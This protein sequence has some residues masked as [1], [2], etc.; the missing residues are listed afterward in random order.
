MTVPLKG[1]W[2][3]AFVTGLCSLVFSAAAM[4]AP[5]VNVYIANFDD[6]TISII[7]SATNTVTATINVLGTFPE[8]VAVTP[9]GSKVLFTLRA[10]TSAGDNSNG[11][12]EILDTATNAVIAQIPTLPGPVGVV[13]APN[14]KTAYIAC[15]NFGGTANLEVLDLGSNTITSQIAVNSTTGDAPFTLAI[16]PD[17]TKLYIVTA[18][19]NAPGG[20]LQVVNVAA[21]AVTASITVGNDPGD[22]AI[23]PNGSQIYVSN[24]DDNSVSVISAAT[25]TVTA[26]IPVG[27]TPFGVAVT[28]DG[29]QAW[30]ANVGDN[31]ISIIATSTNKVISTF[32]A[33]NGAGA[34]A[35]GFTPDGTTAYVEDGSFNV[36]AGDNLVSVINTTSHAVTASI[37]VGA[38][39]ISLGNFI[40]TAPAAAPA[41]SLLSAV[42]PSSRAVAVGAPATIFATILNAS[43]AALGDCQIT[44]PASAPSGLALSYQT[45]NPA[46]NAPTGQPNTPVTIPANGSQSFLL[47]FTSASAF[48][49]PGLALVYSCSGVAQVTPVIGLNTVDLLFSATPIPDIIA[50][51]ATATPGVV[52]VPFSTGGSA[53]F[54]VATDNVGAAGTLTASVDTG[55]ASLPLSLSLCQT[56]SATGACLASPAATASVNFAAGASPTFSVF[57]T[58]S[59]AIPFN[60]ANSRLFVRFKNGGSVSHGSTSVAVMTK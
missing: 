19:A 26:T 22:V 18:N 51:E 44:L 8:G 47:A 5:G 14:G 42:L 56:N 2:L 46:T 35:I 16:S 48:D 20:V 41:A 4:A 59:G 25:N 7:D 29:S 3:C 55:T 9:D 54:A 45:T 10:G 30:V 21:A 38:V 32:P 53:A 58:A 49:Q 33:G 50:L 24:F 31:T 15:N 11:V 52:T 27:I 1:T 13:V 40:A 37:T 57:V 34:N 43:A 28:P 36:G 39:P 17:G 6:N 23:T 12:V 60:P